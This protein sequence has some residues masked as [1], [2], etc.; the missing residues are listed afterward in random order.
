MRLVEDMEMRGKL[1][2][3]HV[4]RAGQARSRRG[5]LFIGWRRLLLLLLLGSLMLLTHFRIIIIITRY[6]K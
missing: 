4:I 6:I 2:Q 1:G 3:Q 5:G